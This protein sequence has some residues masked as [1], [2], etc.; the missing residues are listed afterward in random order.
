M[1]GI[2]TWMLWSP[3]WYYSMR[4]SASTLPTQHVFFMLVSLLTTGNAWASWRLWNCGNWSVDPTPLAIYIGMLVLHGIFLLTLSRLHHLQETII[5]WVLVLIDAGMTGTFTYFAWHNDKWAG[6][7]AIANCAMVLYFV[8]LTV[9]ISMR[10]KKL[11]SDYEKID[12]S[13][14]ESSGVATGIGAPF[15]IQA[16]YTTPAAV[17]AAAVGSVLELQPLPAGIGRGM[18]H[19]HGHV[20]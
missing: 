8:F 3:K 15:T 13:E 5:L 18:S 10:A 7:I 17:P 16:M 1:T 2:L 11:F 19:R 4:L 14:D 9:Q 20:Y 6:V 12:P